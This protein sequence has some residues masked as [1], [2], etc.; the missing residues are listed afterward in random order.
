MARHLVRRPLHAEHRH[1]GDRRRDRPR[2]LDDAAGD[3]RRHRR[4][5]LGSLVAPTRSTIRRCSPTGRRRSITSRTADSCSASAPAGRST[6]T[7]PT[8]SNSNRPSHGSTASKKPS[9]SSGACSRTTGRTF[10]GARYTITDATDGSEAGRSRRADPRR[11]REPADVADHGHACRRVEHVGCPELAGRRRG[12]APRATRRAG[13]CDA[14]DL[15]PGARDRLRRSHRDRELPCWRHG[16]PHIVGSIDQVVDDV[17]GTS[18]TAST[19]SSSRTGSS[20]VTRPNVTAP[21]ST[22]SPP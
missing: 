8:A 12:F 11:H 14:A 17:G 18:I 19:S 13:S 2:M 16:R 7:T 5:R 15:R 20:A 4:V 22:C 1:R 21:S 3:R 6:S 10:D 9:R